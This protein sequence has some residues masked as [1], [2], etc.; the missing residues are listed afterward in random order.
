MLSYLFELILNSLAVVCRNMY[1]EVLLKMLDNSSSINFY[2]DEF[3]VRRNFYERDKPVTFS[4][5]HL[6]RIILIV[7]SGN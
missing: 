7:I 4:M 6:T 1:C 3:F 2:T 5:V